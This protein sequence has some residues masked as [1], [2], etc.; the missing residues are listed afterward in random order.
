MNV[1]AGFDLVGSDVQR[2]LCEVERRGLHGS[3][4]G[5]QASVEAEYNQL[6]GTSSWRCVYMASTA[7]G[8]AA[9]FNIGCYITVG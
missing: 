8:R 3:E 2:P 7:C 5:E 6:F 1:G 4:Q 9:S